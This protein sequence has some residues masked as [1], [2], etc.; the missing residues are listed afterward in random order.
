MLVVALGLALVLGALCP[1]A[2]A[3]GTCP[4]TGQP[5]TKPAVPLTRCM[6]ANE[7]SCCSTCSDIKWVIKD[8]F[9]SRPEVLLQPLFNF[10]TRSSFGPC[11]QSSFWCPG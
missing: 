4:F 8:N 10:L 9:S 7:L 11:T 1:L 2:A 3:Q 5:P 6:D